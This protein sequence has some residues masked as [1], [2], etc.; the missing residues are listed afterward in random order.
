MEAK[1]VVQSG[2]IMK[3]NI[4]EILRRISPIIT[5][6]IWLFMLLFKLVLY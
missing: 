3:N 5:S 1:Y 4:F 6:T 2:V